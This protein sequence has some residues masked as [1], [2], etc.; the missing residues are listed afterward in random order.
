MRLWPVDGTV[1]AQAIANLSRQTL[2]MMKL[3][4]I[5]DLSSLITLAMPMVPASHRVLN[6]TLVLA[7]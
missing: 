6:N 3:V 1:I 5:F 2:V 4:I 7:Q